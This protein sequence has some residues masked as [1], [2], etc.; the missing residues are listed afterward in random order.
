[1]VE[2]S[3]KGVE[4]FKIVVLT[5]DTSE[6]TLCSWL[7]VRPTFSFQGNFGVFGS[8]QT[9]NAPSYFGFIA[10]V[11]G[12]MWCGLFSARDFLLYLLYVS[13]TSV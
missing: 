3:R 5:T 13:T 11:S 8:R 12:F 7:N 6:F 4:F 2:H 1:M 10:L 9:G